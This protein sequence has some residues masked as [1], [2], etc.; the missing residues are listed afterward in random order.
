MKFK[1]QSQMFQ[2]I[3]ENRP[4]FS[5]ISGSPLLPKGHFKWHFQFM[6]ILPKGTFPKYKLNPENIMFGLP[7][8]HEKQET[9]PFF[10]EKKE[11]LRRQ[12]YKEFYNKK[13]D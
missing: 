13:F 7:E 2:W 12:Y 8:E 5:E 3:W 11:Q 10:I 4:H 9:Y 6:H 1:N